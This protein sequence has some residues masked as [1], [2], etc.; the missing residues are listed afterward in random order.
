[1]K[2]EVKMHNGVNTIF[3]D[4]VPHTSPAVYI[5]TRTR[6]ENGNV[7]IDFDSNYFKKLSES[8]FKLFFLECN[9]QW[10]QPEGIK[11]FDRE[12]RLLLEAIPDAYI[13]ARFG[14]HPTNEWIEANPDECVMY[15]DGESPSVHLFT[16][17]YETDMPRMYSLCSQKWREDAGKALVA[18]WKEVMKLPYFDR[19]VC[20][21]PTGGS[22]SEW[23]YLTPLV[24]WSKKRCLGYSKA[25]RREFSDYLRR[26]YK[27][28]EALKKAWKDP[29]A[30]IDNP[31]IPTYEEHYFAGKVDM[32]AAVP[33]HKMLANAPVPPTY[34][35]GTHYGS[36][37]DFENHMHVFD[38]YR[39]WHEGTARSQ[40]Y[41]AKLIKEISPDRLVGTCY[42]AQGCTDI[43]QNGRS[44]GTRLIMESGV[45]D[46]IENPSVYENRIP[47]GSVGQRVAE[48]SFSLNGMV[49]MC[50]D[51]SRTLAENEFFRPKYQVF[52]MVDSINVLKREYGRCICNDMKQW[53]FDQLVGGKRYKYAEMYDL[54]KKQTEITS[55]FYAHDRRKKNEIAYIFSEESLHSVSHHSG[56]DLFELLRNYD[57]SY[58]GASG[59]QYYHNDMANPNMPS[60]K[61]YVFLNC[62]VLTDHERE[63]IKAKLKKDN[64]VAVWMYA[65]GLINP[66]KDVR[67]SVDNIR[68]LTG[69]DMAE[70]NNAHDALFRW[71]G[72]EHKISDRFDRRELFGTFGRL[73]KVCNGNGT[74]TAAHYYETYLYPLFYVTDEKAEHLAYFATS[75]YPA[76]SVKECDGY[77][78]VFY[79]S[80]NINRRVLRSIAEFAGVHIYCDSEDVIYVGSRYITFHAASGG[81]KTIRFPKKC[82][83]Y[84]V[85]ED[86]FYGQ[87]V[88][89]IEFN[90][91]FGE[92]KMF[93][94]TE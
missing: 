72:V 12:A 80:K 25:F 29:D 52:D 28:D 66:E 70:E 64:A 53:W 58:V 22:T 82:D 84:E 37:I 62:F 11:V 54:F 14:M 79:G 48:D 51:D 26:K 65:S 49:Y 4:G 78:S 7:T 27:T 74:A 1:M 81:K 50:Q 2:A 19:I 86:K 91:Y 67:M 83:V 15:S 57:M 45:I 9:T 36:F 31:K 35:N 76:V 93:K 3:I 18:T 92:T 77:T 21:F 75:K 13:I 69:M 88:T 16:E 23:G 10:L 63:V 55:D 42:G 71:D 94:I 20:C 85:Y 17:S 8:G 34:N 46:L 56:R 89:E 43:V 68:E 30:T 5:R 47:G 40:V 73:R 39:C 6:D 61:M 87:G 59:D 41:F 32:D 33:P 90:A 44:A 24:Q 60:Y 38:F